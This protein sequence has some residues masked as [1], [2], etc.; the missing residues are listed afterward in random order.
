MDAARP[1]NKEVSAYLNKLGVKK[2]DFIIISH[3]DMDHI[4]GV[5]TL[6]SYINE[7]TKYYYR[8]VYQSSNKENYD[9]AIKTVQLIMLKVN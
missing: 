9:K 8:A 3:S 4:G 5:P 2:L 7:Y 6:S 1:D